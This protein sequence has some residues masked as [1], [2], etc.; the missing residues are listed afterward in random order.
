MK[1]FKV[2]TTF[3]S[4]S[5]FLLSCA[6]IQLNEDRKVLK[7]ITL[8]E[9]YS[10]S[11]YIPYVRYTTVPI[12]MNTVCHNKDW[13]SVYTSGTPFGSLLSIFTFGIV[14][15]QKIEAVCAN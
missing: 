11:V 14:Q 8:L 9:D 7:K 12:D 15:P 3:L 2:C 4:L 13:Q 6:G 10:Y 5:V 1:K